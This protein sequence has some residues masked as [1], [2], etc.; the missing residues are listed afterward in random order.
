[1][2]TELSEN[3]TK[4]ALDDALRQML[5]RKPL[6]QI[7]VRELTELCGLRRQSFYYHFTDIY[8]L[9]QWSLRQERARLLARQEDFLTWQQALTD[10]M[11]HTA[12]NRSYYQ[13]LLDNHG[14]SGLREVLGPA[15]AGLMEKTHDYYQRYCGGSACSEE[16]DALRECVESIFLS[17]MEG[18]VRAELSQRPEWIVSLAEAGVRHTVISAVWQDLVQ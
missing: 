11:E 5:A 7:R 17:L 15:L 8:A 12:K 13:A 14:R 3:R 16:E 2:P 6:D 10:L 4:N 9:F 1:M 18:W